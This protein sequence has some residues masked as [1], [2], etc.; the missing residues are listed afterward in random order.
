MTRIAL[1]CPS[2]GRAEM[3]G[4]VMES[5]HKTAYDKKRLEIF[6][7]ITNG[8]AQERQY[9][10]MAE[11]AASEFKLNINIVSYVDWTLTMCHN[12][13][14]EKAMNFELHFGIGDDTLFCTPGWDEALV[15]AYE[16]LDNKIHMWSLLDNRDPKGMPAPIITR[17]YI[18]AMGYRVPPI[19]M[20]W[21][22]DT[23]TTEIAKANNCIT[24][25][26]EYLLFHDKQ[27]EQGIKD[28]AYHRIRRRG[29]FERDFYV[30]ETCKHFLEVEKKR[31]A[32]ALAS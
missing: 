31:L 5:V 2:Y 11:K 16:A 17:E 22:A 24:H 3:C 4:L 32:K 7:A 8:D 18:K 15:K 21:Y 6:I 19:F 29:G 28:E 20:H 26:T 27:S 23:W 12:K 9:L 1:L 30:S 13:L 10:D 14:S 25:L